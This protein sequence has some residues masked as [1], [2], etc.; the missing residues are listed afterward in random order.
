MLLAMGCTAGNLDG[1]T[2]SGMIEIGRIDLWF[3]A[4]CCEAVPLGTI[5]ISTPF[6]LVYQP[7][8]C[9]ALSLLLCVF[10]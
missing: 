10:R 8:R 6:S 2:A 9:S 3:V 5:L 4:V 1:G 7:T